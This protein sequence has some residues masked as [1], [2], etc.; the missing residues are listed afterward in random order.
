MRAVSVRCRLTAPPGTAFTV[1]G[2]AIEGQ[3]LLRDVILLVLAGLSLKLTP[4]PVRAGNE[5]S[6]GP[7]KEVAKLFASI[8]ISLFSTAVGALVDSGDPATQIQLPQ[9]TGHWL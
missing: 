1:H 8:F 2:V 6:W 7:I 5:F 3:N 4:G 9:G